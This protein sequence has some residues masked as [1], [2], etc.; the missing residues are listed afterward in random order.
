MESITK[1]VWAT[2]I[3]Y[4]L[5][6]WPLTVDEI[7]RL[8]INPQRWE[9]KTKAEILTLPLTVTREKIKNLIIQALDDLKTK[10]IVDHYLGFYFL[11]SRRFLVGERLEKQKIAEL[12]W[13]KARRYLRLIPLLPLVEAVLASGSLALGNTD[14]QSDLDVL[15][16]TKAQRIWLARLLITGLTSLLGVRR[17]AK[18][19]RGRPVSDKICLNHYITTGSLTI[20][21][22]SLYNAQTYL[23]LTPLYLRRPEIWSNFWAA[24]RWVKDFVLFSP[25]RNEYQWRAIASQQGLKFFGLAVEKFLEFFGLARLLN[26]GAKHLQK[27]RI[28]TDLPGRVIAEDGQ[29]E[30]HPFS[31]EKEILNHYNQM[32]QATD[33]F[34]DYREID[35]GL[36]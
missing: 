32:I 20:P 22:P 10:Q 24:N 35:S 11:A 26:A 6:G 19:Q 23:H 13:Q 15:V 36:K 14:E 21:W 17:K 8:L 29:L 34:P 33:Q 18:D 1:A 16:I 5:W 4:D 31:R 12:K 2:L 28:Q 30:F 9:A 3:Y 25:V 7:T 27:R